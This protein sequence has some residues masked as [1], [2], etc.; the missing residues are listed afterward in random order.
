MEYDEINLRPYLVAIGRRW[1]WILIGAVLAAAVAAGISLVLPKEYE[2]TA[3]ILVA[4]RESSIGS[5]GP[6]LNIDTIDVNARRQGLVALAQTEAIEARLPSDFLAQLEPD[7]YRPGMLLKDH[8]ILAYSTGDLIGIRAT[9]PT[10]EQTQQLANVWARAF[11]AYVPELYNDGFTSVA[12]AGEA[13]LPIEPSGPKIVRNS[14]LG[15]VLGATLGL[16]LAML[17]TVV[18][19]PRFRGVPAAASVPGRPSPTR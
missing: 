15:A 5:D 14:A 19:L 18:K 17:A 7:D 9:G 11:S 4:I 13:L 2:A 6:L 12:V 8:R 16:G 1:H 10:A 3:N